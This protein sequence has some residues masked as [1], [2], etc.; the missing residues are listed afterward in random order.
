VC[1][2]VKRELCVCVCV[3]VS[4]FCGAKFQIFWEPNFLREL[5][6]WWKNVGE[7]YMETR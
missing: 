7:Y 2:S 5:C 3:C 4:V 6:E 1:E